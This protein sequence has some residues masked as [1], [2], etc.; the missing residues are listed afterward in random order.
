MVIFRCFILFLM[1][2]GQVSI[3][4]RA[5]T[6]D[7]LLR[8]ESITQVKL[9][10]DG[11]WL[12]YVRVRPKSAAETYQKFFLFGKDRG[13][14]W[15]AA[16]EGGSPRNLTQGISDGSGWWAPVWSPDSRR[17]ALLSNRG[18]NVRLWVL[19]L[20]TGRIQRLTDLAVDVLADPPVLWVSNEHLLC[21]AL[22]E[23][24]KPRYLSLM[25]QAQEVA[26]REWPEA[27]KGKRSTA[28]VLESGREPWQPKGY[29]LRVNAK[30]GS[31]QK[32][33][34]GSVQYLRLSPDGRQV[35]LARSL[36]RWPVSYA[37]ALGLRIRSEIAVV[38]LEAHPTVSVLGRLDDI[39][40]PYFRWRPDGRALIAIAKKAYQ[41]AEVQPEDEL[42][43]IPSPSGEMRSLTSNRFLPHEVVAD[44]AGKLLMLAQPG[45]DRA[46]RRKARRDWWLLDGVSSPRNLTSDMKRVPS[47]LVTGIDGTHFAGV[48]E[49]DLWL[50][51]TAGAPPKNLTSAVEQKMQWIV[52]PAHGSPQRGQ[53]NRQVIAEASGQGQNRNFYLLSLINPG[54]PQPI[55][56]PSENAMLAD[57]SDKASVAAI[58]GETR[59]GTYLWAARPSSAN[60]QSIVRLNAYWEELAEQK[61]Q[62]FKYRSLKDE[63]LTGL[64]IYPHEYKEGQRYPLIVCV[65]PGMEEDFQLWDRR[66]YPLISRG[67]AVLV[68]SMPLYPGDNPSAPMSGMLNGVMPAIDKVVEMGVADPDRLAVM[69][70]SY[71]GYAALSLITQT[72]RFKAAIAK[73]PGSNWISLYGGF[74]MFY[75]YSTYAHEDLSFFYEIEIGQVQMKAPPWAEPTR[76]I[77]NSP[78]F[79]A[80]QVQTP[81][82]II[83]GDI[84][85]VSI[86][87]GEEFFMALFRQGKRARFVRYWGEGHSI[88][89]PANIRDQW[90]QILGWLDDHLKPKSETETR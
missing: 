80:H 38:T 9:S 30:D 35:A 27:V 36:G 49:G 75:R 73:S 58:T 24:E 25:V 70:A 11:R 44:P 42:F 67:Y 72:N 54:E 51:S 41:P 84:D 47:A 7:D 68:P 10:P 64:L 53:P 5:F 71:G 29:L 77:Q 39:R 33:A 90:K 50:L 26:T 18:G 21:A 86:G 46:E 61:R 28:S 87:Q 60:Y 43:L 20:A 1:A 63:Q 57:W 40:A 69:G 88:D 48:A 81:V 37:G 65:Y 79:R 17:L 82:M 2:S 52:W 13:D 22:R 23:G 4:Q 6:V 15:L 12:A 56:K 76:Y 74:A 3:A 85:Y 19:D 89:S 16:T 14:I 59:N 32:L 55:P 45:N 83:Q 34:D 62:T 78:I 66:L 8:E 31:V